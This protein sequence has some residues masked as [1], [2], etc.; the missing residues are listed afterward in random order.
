MKKRLLE[1][2]TNLVG[3][4]Q[5]CI[6][7]VVNLLRCRQWAINALANIDGMLANAPFIGG[8]GQQVFCQGAV[9]VHQ[10]V[11]VELGTVDVFYQQLDGPLVVQ[12]H[13][14]FKGGFALGRLAVLDEFKCVEPG[15]RVAFQ[16]ARCPG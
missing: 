14:C 7:C 15:V 12:D 2:V 3:F 4:A 16:V 1:R 11:A 10:G 5:Q 8:V 6:Q 9:Q 13:L